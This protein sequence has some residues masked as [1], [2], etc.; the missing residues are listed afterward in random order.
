[1]LL[2]EAVVDDR[3]DQAPVLGHL[4]L[5]LDHRGDDQH[6]VVAEV[7][8]VGGLAVER[9]EGALERRE[10]LGDEVARGRTCA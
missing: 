6:V 4:R 8:A 10:L 2:L 3:R 5:A 1:M 9:V 7:L